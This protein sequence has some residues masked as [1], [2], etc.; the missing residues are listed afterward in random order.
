MLVVFSLVRY[1]E[2]SGSRIDLQQRIRKPAMNTAVRDARINDLPFLREMLYEAIFWRRNPDTPGFKEAMQLDF[3]QMAL[4]DWGRRS[5]DL[6]VIAVQDTKPVGAAWYR[7]WSEEAEIRGYIR[8]DVPVLAI[9]VKSDCRGQGIGGVLI[10]HLMTR[11]SAVSV[12]RIS[13]AVSKDNR[14]LGLY[15]RKGFR[16]HTDIEHSYLMIRD[17]DI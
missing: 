7:F 10:D 8:E 11:A 15:R 16:V 9:A 2:Y 17:T 13:L 4:E 5:G 1:V 14:A 12:D 3:V 6:A